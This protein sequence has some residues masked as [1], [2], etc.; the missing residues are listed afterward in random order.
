MDG[1]FQINNW[2]I[3][4]FIMVILLIQIGFLGLTFLDY[5]GMNIP[6]I[7]EF[8]AVIYI[9]FV[10]G[11]LLLRIMGLNEIKSSIE[12]VLFVVGLSVMIAMF[13]GLFM[14]MVY[15][16]FG[17]FQPLSKEC[18]IYT[19]LVFTTILCILCILKDKNQYKTDNIKKKPSLNVFNLLFFIPF[20]NIR[21]YF[22]NFNYNDNLDYISKKYLLNPY[23]LFLILLPFIS[24][25]GT[26]LMN[27][28]NN[29]IILISLIIIICSILLL[30]SFNKGFSPDLYPL[31]IFSI[32]ISLL[33]H[34]SLISMYIWG[35]DIN[36]EYYT[37]NIVI[38]NLIWNTAVQ[39][40]I[41]SIL[42]VSILA[43][44]LSNISGISLVWIYKVV[45]PFLFSLVPLGLYRIFQKQ[46]SNK[47]SFLATF[48]FMATFTFYTEIVSITKQEIA[49]LFL[50][51]ILLILIN[52]DL[53][54]TKGS[55]LLILFSFSLIVSHYGLSYILC[56]LFV[57]YLVIFYAV[58]YI[59]RFRNPDTTISSGY[60]TKLTATFIIFF[61]SS[62]LSWYM[63]SSG[64]SCFVSLVQIGNQ[65]TSNLLSIIKPNTSQGLSV[66]ITQQ[67]FFLAE[68]N[69]L[70]YLIIQFSI[71]VGVL[72]TLFKD[73]MNF[74][75]EYMLLSVVVLGMLIAG[76]VVPY[77][78]SQIN[79]SRLFHIGI[80]FLAPFAIIG[81]LKL[82]DLF[83]FLKVKI[84]ND[85]KLK[86]ISLFLVL[87]LFFDSGLAY[88][89]G[90][91][92]HA[93][94]ISIQQSYDSPVFNNMELS[95]AEWINNY[96]NNGYM[97]YA[98]V[99]RIYLLY[100]ILNNAGQVPFYLDLINKNSYVFLG[101]YDLKEKRILVNQMEGANIVTNQRYLPLNVITSSYNKIYDNGGSNVYFG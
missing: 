29:N 82:L 18:L 38:H 9:L 62:V 51:L 90:G 17:I 56:L 10:P 12:N 6:I 78:S 91:E 21:M 54:N 16:V 77:F 57:A 52:K 28:Y 60:N 86:I 58:N 13:I 46:T 89:I 81:F 50:V 39:S 3:K 32:S 93:S 80:I 84:K 47:I 69:K 79:T 2:K 5:A 45:Y 34:Q 24:V 95:G 14:N 68:I 65:I 67:A 19:F 70:L 44:V 1:V 27:F 7:K 88:Y 92:E 43:P 31:A 8:I 87:F 25:F 99:I 63:Y 71:A 61:I 96:R 101:S 76:V 48:L 11:M 55:L 64:A 22:R 59:K 100:G 98:D 23:A 41:N 75:K 66:V 26:Y 4:N 33:L 72:A 49:E 37:A 97:V 30:V 42:S 40:N 20:T 73:K 83:N 85:N 15:P 53:R 35:W 74:T 94:S 36:V